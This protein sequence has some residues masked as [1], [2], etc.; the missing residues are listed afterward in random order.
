L[1]RSYTETESLDVS[2]EPKQTEYPPKQLK[3]EYIWVFFRKFRVVSVCFGLLRNR[4]VCFACFNIGS[5]HQNK[6]KFFVFGF[7][8]QTE[9]NA[10]QILFRFVS[11]RTEIYFC[12]FRGHP[13]S[14]RPAPSPPPASAPC[15][16][17]R[18]RTPAPQANAASPPMVIQ[19]ISA[20]YYSTSGFWPRMR[21]RAL[22][23]HV[24]LGSITCQTG[25]CAP[26]PHPWQLRC[27]PKN[28][29]KYSRNK[30]L[31]FW[32]ELRPPGAYIFQLG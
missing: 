18:T 32:P 26:P 17:C 27:A 22:R 19:I 1:F 11:V 7:T 2:I 8:N 29:N 9:T 20:C 15:R 4:S 10:K 14:G 12:L 16:G 30:I 3:R 25:R 28:K 24:F 6:P 13:T 23:A 5:K 31:P 21:V